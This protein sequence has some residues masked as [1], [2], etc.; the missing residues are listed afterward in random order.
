M[1]RIAFFVE[2]LTE[3]LFLIKFIE[4]VYGKT[5][6]AITSMK[7]SGGNRSD[8]SFTTITADSITTE[9]EYYILI[10]DCGGDSNLRSYIMDQ[11]NSLAKN[12]YSKIIGIR[13]VYPT[14]RSDAHRLKYGLYYELPQNPISIDFVLSVMEIEAWFLSEHTHFRR[15]DNKLSPSLINQSLSFHPE[16]EDME[17]R[18]KPAEDLHNTYQLVGKAYNKDRARVERTVNAID[19]SELY[20]NTKPQSL[21]QLKTE[22]ENFFS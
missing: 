15:I 20:F 16:N 11:R 7:G 22:L 6:I 12:E 9:T 5:R 14:P 17:L 4:E 2:G 10:V 13:D 19:Y 21:I 18:E 1:R 3:Q 8:I